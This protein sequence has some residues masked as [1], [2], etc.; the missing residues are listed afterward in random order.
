MLAVSCFGT[1]MHTNSSNVP[2]QVE[3]IKSMFFPGVETMSTS[4][5]FEYRA[6]SDAS[7]MIESAAPKVHDVRCL[8]PYTGSHTAFASSREARELRSRGAVS[9]CR[10]ASVY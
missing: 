6:L 5:E 2:L 3:R 8:H 7:L 4:Q 10:V 9:S 1:A